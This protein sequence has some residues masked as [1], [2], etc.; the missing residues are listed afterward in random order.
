M[1]EHA[2]RRAERIADRREREKDN[3]RADRE[4]AV[5][6]EKGVADGEDAPGVTDWIM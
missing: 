5:D 3:A 4:R 6:A 2:R 1:K